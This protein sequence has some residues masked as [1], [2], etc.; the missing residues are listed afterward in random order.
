MIMGLF[1]RGERWFEGMLSLSFASNS[2][3]QVN[4]KDGW[5]YHRNDQSRHRGTSVFPQRAMWFK[6][7]TP[8][9]CLR[10]PQLFKAVKVP[11]STNFLSWPVTCVSWT[12]SWVTHRDTVTWANVC[13]LL[14]R[15]GYQGE[16]RSLCHYSFIWRSLATLNV[17]SITLGL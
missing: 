17:L 12:H 16:V 1:F 14:E 11:E 13:T 6:H 2:T 8:K 5:E 4:Q 10:R 7:S 3:G 9:D 15:S